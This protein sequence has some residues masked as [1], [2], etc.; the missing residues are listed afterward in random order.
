VKF[1]TATYFL[2]A[3]PKKPKPTSDPE[4]QALVDHAQSIRE[5]S[6]ELI[7]QMQALAKE[8]ERVKDRREQQRRRDEEFGRRQRKP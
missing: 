5:S 7:R 2:R 6:A 3:V 4:L 8:I 1:E